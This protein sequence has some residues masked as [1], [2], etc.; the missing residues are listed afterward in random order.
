LIAD[1]VDTQDRFSIYKDMGFDYFQGYFFAEPES[2]SNKNLPTSK[3]TLVE[4]MGASSSES[5]DIEG[6]NSC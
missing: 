6:I 4:I 5:F 3:L 2:V 1:Q